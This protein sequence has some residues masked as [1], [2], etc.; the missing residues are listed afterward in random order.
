MK[1]AYLH[2][3]LAQIKRYFPGA[4]TVA[5][6]TPF[7]LTERTIPSPRD[8]L[9]DTTVDRLPADNTLSARGLLWTY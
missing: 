4:R 7:D 1:R 9:R 8:A 6:R 5:L 3:D 2:E